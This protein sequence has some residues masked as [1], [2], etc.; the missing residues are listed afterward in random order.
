MADIGEEDW[1]REEGADSLW[2]PGGSPVKVGR[3]NRRGRSR[4][5]TGT[6]ARRVRKEPG[7]AGLFQG[8]QPSGSSGEMGT[9]QQTPERWVHLARPGGDYE[10]GVP[11]GEGHDSRE[12]L[13]GNGTVDWRQRHSEHLGSN[14]SPVVHPAG[15][16]GY[17]PSAAGE[18]GDREGEDT[19]DVEME[20][21]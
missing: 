1:E 6:R 7:G 3:G 16:I 2:M 9:A 4:G 14:E 17:G 8:H 5:R 13:G 15:D 12:H 18:A 20:D 11:G 10:R 19:G 21:A